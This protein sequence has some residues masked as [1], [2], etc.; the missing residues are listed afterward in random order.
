MIYVI[1]I[2]KIIQIKNISVTLHLQLY[3]G[4]S[5]NILTPCL[6]NSLNIF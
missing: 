5:V 3:L 4:L 2:S 1:K 6:S